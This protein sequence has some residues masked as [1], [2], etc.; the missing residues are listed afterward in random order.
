MLQQ[1]RVTAVLLDP[2]R[3]DPQGA[4][5]AIPLPRQLLA[6]QERQDRQGIALLCNTPNLTLVAWVHSSFIKYCLFSKQDV[7]QSWSDL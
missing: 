5:L 3:G 6:L 7:L 1:K 2:S 4:T